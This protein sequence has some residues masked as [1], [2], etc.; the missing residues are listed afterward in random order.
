MNWVQK[1]ILKWWPNEDL[2]KLS[3]VEKKLKIKVPEYLLKDFWNVFLNRKQTKKM[4]NGKLSTEELSK[5]KLEQLRW[6]LS[7]NSV[8]KVNQDINKSNKIE[9]EWTLEL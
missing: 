9:D 7:Q 2:I 3:E 5:L 4:E 8:E 1:E 6:N